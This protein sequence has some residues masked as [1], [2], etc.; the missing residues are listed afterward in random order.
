MN[1]LLNK[2]KILLQGKGSGDGKLSK[3]HYFLLLLAAGISFMLIS[4]LLTT[5]QH[6]GPSIPASEEAVQDDA[7]V[8]KSSNEAEKGSIKDYENQYETQLKEALET[9]IGVEDVTVLVNVDA[10][11]MKV[12]EK[13]RVSQSQTTDESDREGGTRKVTDQQ[14][15]EQVVMYKNGEQETPLVLQT[16]KPDI[17]GVL[18]VAKGADNV[19]IKKNIIDAVTRVLGVPSHQVAVAAKKG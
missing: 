19:Q 7:E 6:A 16:K 4:N 12:I 17:R 14:I 9:M 5:E 10:T 18:V 1:D 15:D 13:N 2:L 3:S 8:F 11:S